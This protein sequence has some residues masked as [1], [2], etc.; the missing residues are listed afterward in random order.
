MS[1]TNAIGDFD[2]NTIKLRKKIEFPDGTIQSTAATDGNEDLAEVLTVGNDA[3]G[4]D[5]LGVGTLEVNTQIQLTSAGNTV[6]FLGEI[7]QVAVGNFFNGNQLQ[8]TLINSGAGSSTTIGLQVNDIGGTQGLYVLPNALNNIY[9]PIVNAN[10]VVVVANSTTQSLAICCDSTTTNGIRISDTTMTM[11]VGGNADAPTNSLTFNNPANTIVATANGGG[12]IVQTTAA[13]NNPTLTVKETTTNNALIVL[14]KSSGGQYNPLDTNTA[15]EIVGFIDG[16]TR[17]NGQQLAIVPHSETSCGIRMVSGTA[18]SGT[19]AYLEVGC[20]GTVGDPSQR[21]RFD[22][23]T[24]QIQMTSTAGTEIKG[25]NLI[26]D[27]GLSLEFGDGSTQATAAAKTGYSVQDGGGSTVNL[28]S[29]LTYITKT[30]TGLA[31]GAYL[32]YGYIKVQASGGNITNVNIESYNQSESG[33]GGVEATLLY[34]SQINSGDEIYLPISNAFVND[35]G[36]TTQILSITPTYGGA[37][38]LNQIDYYLQLYYLGF[39]Q[40]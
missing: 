31:E 1:A 18:G 27:T 16:T 12:M 7:N 37:G 39:K 40:V 34:T 33:S 2:L 8:P 9:N 36:D 10:D 17:D 22:N 19:N 15:V 3:D 11:G 28:P 20:G 6:N 13:G 24:S 35:T 38:T 5:I 21:I 4:Q 26:L 30:W 32:Q 25:A 23:A 14:P 29:G